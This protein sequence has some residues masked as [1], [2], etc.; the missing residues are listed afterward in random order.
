MHTTK[1]EPKMFQWPGSATSFQTNV[2]SPNLIKLV[3]FWDIRVHMMDIGGDL[4]VGD[5]ALDVAFDQGLVGS[6]Q[7]RVSWYVPI[8]ILLCR[9]WRFHFDE[10]HNKPNFTVSPARS[11][12]FWCV[13]N[14]GGD[15]ANTTNSIWS[16]L[17]G[18]KYVLSMAL[19]L[20][21]W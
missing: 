5:V 3:R 2:V 21:L 17:G 6:A 12:R 14:S 16:L 19:V 1:Q 18:G 8:F 20:R 9:R 15:V 4:L 13:Y 7:R 11:R 10:D